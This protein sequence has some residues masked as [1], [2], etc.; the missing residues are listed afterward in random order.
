MM[1]G[2]LYGIFT[3]FIST[4]AS[5]LKYLCRGFYSLSDKGVRSKDLHSSEQVPLSEGL[6]LF[7][8]VAID[9]GL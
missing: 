8:T 9:P 7:T 1:A 6:L 4:A 5:W 2:C 3:L